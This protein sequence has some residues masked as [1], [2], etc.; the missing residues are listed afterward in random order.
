MKSSWFEIKILSKIDR[1]NSFNSSKLV[2]Q[3]LDEKQV[4]N[5]AN[6]DCTWEFFVAQHNAEGRNNCNNSN[7]KRKENNKENETIKKEIVK[8]F[9]KEETSA[10]TK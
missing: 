1:W 4:L 3:I 10:A 9:Q 7:Y 5:I 2:P 8:S 6:N